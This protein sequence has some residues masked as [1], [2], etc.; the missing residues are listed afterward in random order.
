[1]CYFGVLISP[2]FQF[3]DA[4]LFAVATPIY[5][6]RLGGLVAKACYFSSTMCIEEM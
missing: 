6:W 5:V 3:I 1:M 4:I 2:K